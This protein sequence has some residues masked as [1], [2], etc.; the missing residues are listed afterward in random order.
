MEF[1]FLL[2]D[3]QKKSSFD[4]DLFGLVSAFLEAAPDDLDRPGDSL[5]LGVMH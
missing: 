3:F 2:M 5:N 4:I 1:I